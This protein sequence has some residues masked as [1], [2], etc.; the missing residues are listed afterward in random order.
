[1]AVQPQGWSAVL[2]DLDGTLVDTRPGVRS[3]IAAAFEEVTGSA[4][5]TGDL[6]LSLPLDRMI[7]T[8]APLAPLAVQE[9]LVAA[10]RRFYDAGL[11]QRACAYDG[12]PECL[13]ALRSGGVRTF[14]VTNK[15]SSAA[16]QLLSYLGLRDYVEAI[17]GQPDTGDAV[18]K[19]ELAR[20]CLADAGLDPATTVV[21]GDSDHDA[22]MAAAWRMIFIA[23]TSGAGPLVRPNDAQTRLEAANLT[24][25]AA[26]VLSP[27]PGRES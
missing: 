10:F 19:A 3:A 15:R 12:A 14:V 6:D 24:D 20:R 27:V 8:A 1:M 17:V 4:P 5:L 11:W 23:M 25:V 22:A 26:M 9:Q 2:F 16:E 7:R 13:Q 18:P 21:V